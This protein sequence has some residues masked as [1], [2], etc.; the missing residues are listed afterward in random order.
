M[1]FSEQSGRRNTLTKL[2][3][4]YQQTVPA[5][6]GRFQTGVQLYTPCLLESL[7]PLDPVWK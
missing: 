2:T 7:S 6:Q 3:H 1:I 4:Q 5:F